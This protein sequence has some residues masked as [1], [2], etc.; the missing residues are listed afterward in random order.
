[1]YGL[2]YIHLSTTSSRFKNYLVSLQYISAINIAVIRYSA[3]K[4][5]IIGQFLKEISS[6]YGESP[7]FFLLKTTLTTKKTKT[8]KY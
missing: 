3:K 5:R 7:L 6:N 8:M 1:M 4:H 2:N